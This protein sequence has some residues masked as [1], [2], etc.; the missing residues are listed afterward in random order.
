V[1]AD[2]VDFVT[3]DLVD[4][5]TADLVDFVTADLFDFV[6]ADLVD[7]VTADLVDF[8]TADWVEFMAPD[9]VDSVSIPWPQMLS[10][11]WIS[12]PQVINF[13]AADLVDFVTADLVDFVTAGF[14]GFANAT[15]ASA[16]FRNPHGAAQSRVLV[17]RMGYSISPG[18]Q[19]RGPFPGQGNQRPRR[20]ARPIVSDSDPLDRAAI[21][22]QRLKNN[23]LQLFCFCSFTINSIENVPPEKFTFLKRTIND[24]Q[25]LVS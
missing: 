21:A 14:A 7:F 22:T 13:V 15:P 3:A 17:H 2:L 25:N 5:V 19:G 1:V 24:S 23:G 9:A 10:V 20:R 12:W 16:Q 11:W 6:T 8:V 18:G 4:L